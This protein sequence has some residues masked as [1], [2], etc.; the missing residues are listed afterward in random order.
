MW[1][2]K[3]ICIKKG[4]HVLSV[5]DI[6]SIHLPVGIRGAYI[7]AAVLRLGRTVLLS[8]WRRAVRHSLSGFQCVHGCEEKEV[9]ETC[10]WEESPRQTQKTL[11]EKHWQMFHTISLFWRGPFLALCGLAMT[12][13]QETDPAADFWYLWSRTFSAGYSWTHFPSRQIW[14]RQL[15]IFAAM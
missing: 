10:H 3:R 11:H 2:N 7:Y 5:W 6:P 4:D 9:I 15:N 14:K 1:K 13:C 8:V 12:Q